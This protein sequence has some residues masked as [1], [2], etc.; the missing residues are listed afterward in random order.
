M[1]LRFLS[2][3]IL[4]NWLLSLKFIL[5]SNNFG[6][7]WTVSSFSV[8]LC[9]WTIWVCHNLACLIAIVIVVIKFDTLFLGFTF[10]YGCFLLLGLL[11]CDVDRFD[12]GFFLLDHSQ[13]L[14]VVDVHIVFGFKNGVGAN[15]LPWRLIHID[16]ILRNLAWCLLR[17]MEIIRNLI[18]LFNSILSCWVLPGH[19]CRLL[20][21]TMDPVFFLGRE[22]F[23][24]FGV[25]HLTSIKQLR[26]VGSTLVH[27]EFRLTLIIFCKH[28]WI[29][30]P[31]LRYS[32]GHVLRVYRLISVLCLKGKLNT[33]H[34]FLLH[35][36]L[37]HLIINST[38]LVLGRVLAFSF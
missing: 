5:E 33:N 29:I 8:R 1:P 31:R 38:L 27:N 23:F 35:Q 34:W 13:M 21:D 19:R 20:F 4:I 32:F 3:S 36:S 10:Y 30:S 6:L 15:S 25:K 16:L 24:C 26:D 11:L 22:A 12:P 2:Q 28:I 17:R 9:K 7:A 18:E 14:W 37:F